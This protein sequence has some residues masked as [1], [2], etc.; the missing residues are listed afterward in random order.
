LNKPFAN[1]WLNLAV[2]WELILLVLVIYLPFLHKAFSTYAL[3]LV[4]WLIVFGL[5]FSVMPVLEIAKWME[6]RGW[7]GKVD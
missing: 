5:A 6:R 1:K 2:G 3:P 7:F 4:D